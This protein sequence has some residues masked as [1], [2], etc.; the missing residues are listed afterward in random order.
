MSLGRAVAMVV[1][2]GAPVAALWYFGGERLISDQPYAGFDYDT[3]I[4]QVWRVLEGLQGW[5]RSWVYDVQHLAGYPNGTIFD[6][7]NKGWELWT[8]A[9]VELGVS[10]GQ[11]FNSFIIASHLAV[12]PTVYAAARLFGLRPG[13]SLVAASFALAYWLFDGWN[14][15]EWFVG[16]VAYGWASYF[17]LLPLAAFYRWLA[18]RRPRHAIVCALTLAIAHQIH[19]YSFFALV[20]P[21]TAL[22][23]RDAK[24]LSR[25]EHA[26]VWGMAAVAV[27]ANAWWLS[28][29]LSFWH[30]ILDSSLFADP[31]LD[32]LL[33]DI[34]GLLG[35]PAAM[36]VIGNR[37]GFRL[38]LVAGAFVGIGAWW[39]RADDRALPF[40]VGLV[41]MLC[42]TYLGGYTFFANIQP[43]RHVGPLGFLATIPAAAALD[44]A[45]RERLWSRLSRGGRALVVVL[46][47]PAVVHLARDVLYFTAH[48][49]P[50]PA[51]LPDGN[52][53]WFSMLGYGPHGN[54]GYGDWQHE[55][56]ATWARE[57][58]DRRG[59]VMI[60]SWHV[61]EQL[62]WKTNTQVIGGFIWRNLQHSWANYF[63][64]RPQGLGEP[65]EFRR[66]LEN[67]AV[68]WVLIA[69]PRDQ[70]PWWDQNPL[71]EYETTIEHVRVYRSKVRSSLLAEGRGRITAQTNRLLVEGSDPNEDVVLRYHWLE[72]LACG[73]DCRIEREP[74]D[75][76][77]VGFIRVPAP[78][79][80]DFEIRN[81]YRRMAEP[82]TF[83]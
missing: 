48:S 8:W 66:Y 3:H 16:M 46:A 4:S 30:Y 45:V 55:A 34:F 28:V 56:I 80:A 1:V 41:A 81:M 13:A 70:A 44:L 21:M 74:I 15:W 52:R 35:D 20:A 39:R 18:D 68:H 71:L 9:L 2:F 78:H 7:D 77:A 82:P 51:A 53:I 17:F 60:D 79:P 49:L 29:A 73:P 14:H 37:T 43:H 75:T 27:L 40:F 24:H 63:R 33:W 12:T 50:K 19:P 23:L 59:R 11:A 54:F 67:Y 26:M 47:L 6:A 36:G 69:T 10:P 62:T 61:G 5:G 72:T 22:Y 83:D 64:L 25:H 42:L 57:H 31:T 32:S 65:E 38:A 58:D 76:D